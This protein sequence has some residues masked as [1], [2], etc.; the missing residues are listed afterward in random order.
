MA[1]GRAPARIRVGN[2]ESRRD[3]MD[4]RDTVRA[5][6]LLLEKQRPGGIYNLASG[7]AERIGGL[8]ERLCDLAGVR[9]DIAADPALHRPTDPTPRLDL[10]AIRTATGRY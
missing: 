5:Y 6:P 9:P 4:V 3:F 2:L 1:A 8:L 7:R 10:G